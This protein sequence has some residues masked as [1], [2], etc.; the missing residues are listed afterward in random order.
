MKASPGRAMMIS[1]SV[2]GWAACGKGRQDMHVS[3]A[4][5]EWVCVSSRRWLLN[6]PEWGTALSQ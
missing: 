3:Y 6:L 1:I 2:S 5:L 4:H